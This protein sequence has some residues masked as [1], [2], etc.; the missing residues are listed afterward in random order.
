[1]NSDLTYCEKVDE[2]MDAFI[3][4]CKRNGLRLTHQR[5]EIYRE[6]AVAGDHPSAEMIY[7]RVRHR[8]PTISLDTVYRTLSSLETHQIIARVG[9]ATSSAR[10][11]S[12]PDPHDHFVCVRCGAIQDVFALTTDRA[13]LARSVPENYEVHSSHIEL[14]GLCPS[15]TN[16]DAGAGK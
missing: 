15:C 1:M 6:L 14:R 11:E 4:A 7:R 10:F 9:A 12:N 2:H 8:L 3:Q 16:G 13:A 5:I